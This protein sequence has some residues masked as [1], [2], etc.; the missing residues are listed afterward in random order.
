M[1]ILKKKEFPS[2]F[3]LKEMTESNTAKRLGISNV[4]TGQV[5]DNLR[6]TATKLIEVRKLLAK[7]YDPNDPQSTW[8]NPVII[9]SGY[10]S[11]ELNKHIPGSSDTSAHTLG[12]AADIKCPNFGTPYQVAAKIADSGIKFDQLI[13]EYG[14]WVHISFDPRMRQQILTIDKSGTRS[15]L[16][17]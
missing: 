13:Y 17:L 7:F 16:H 15:G 10:R 8:F 2:E 6:T 1:A 3:T 9:N 12:W 14:S 4:P 5:L 11:P